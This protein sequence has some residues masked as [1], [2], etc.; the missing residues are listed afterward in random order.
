VLRELFAAREAPVDVKYALQNSAGDTEHVTTVS[1]AVVGARGL[2]GG[3]AG[4][5]NPRRVYDSARDRARPARWPAHPGSRRRQGTSWCPG[6]GFVDT[7]RTVAKQRWAGPL[8]LLMQRVQ[9]SVD[10]PI[11]DATGL[12]GNFEWVLTFGWGANPPADVPQ[13]FAALQE[14]LGL[15]LEAR[16]GPVEVLVVDA[17]ELPTP[18]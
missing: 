9:F 3:T 2:A 13:L 18:D 17:V 5:K 1:L 14:Q 11:V 4:W 7:S 6:P 16:Q 12:S 10:R 8:R 15:K